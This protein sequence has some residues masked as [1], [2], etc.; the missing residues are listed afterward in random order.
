MSGRKI[1]L[2]FSFVLVALCRG[3]DAKADE[4]QKQLHVDE[5]E[6]AIARSDGFPSKWHGVW[7]G[8]VEVKQQPAAG[9]SDNLKGG[10]ATL[11]LSVEDTTKGA[12]PT[13]IVIGTPQRT[14]VDSGGEA[15]RPDIIFWHDP[16]EKGHLAVL[17]GAHIVN[18]QADGKTV[19]VNG[20]V[21]IGG[22]GQVIFGR[23]T[24]NVNTSV[25]EGATVE[26]ANDPHGQRVPRAYSRGVPNGVVDDN[27]GD[28]LF[29]GQT[30]YS[31]RYF[32]ADDRVNITNGASIGAPRVDIGSATMHPTD[33][34]NVQGNRDVGYIIQRMRGFDNGGSR[35]AN[36]M[37]CDL[38]AR[39]DPRMTH[40]VQVTPGVFEQKTERSVIGADGRLIGMQR[41]LARYYT[42]DPETIRVDIQVDA[43]DGSLGGPVLMHGTLH[44][45]ASP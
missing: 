12:H 40:I 41:V 34:I 42:I 4:P 6:S 17:P 19:Y 18:R 28:I 11:D 36:S 37:A 21:F 25:P 15:A 32:K 31:G 5:T 16:N 3:M 44:K 23:P 1:F 35:S 7:H 33:W 29:F 45:S 20:N 22:T 24:A 43:D 2:T 39:S 10:T 14:V 30:A 38:L 9:G 13:S 27:N 26:V 8:S